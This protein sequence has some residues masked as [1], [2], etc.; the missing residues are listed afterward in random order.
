[1][2]KCTKLGHQSGRLNG[3]SSPSTR[4]VRNAKSFSQI[5]RACL[6]SLNSVLHRGVVGVTYPA[7]LLIAH[8]KATVAFAKM[9]RGSKF[10]TWVTATTVPT[11]LRMVTMLRGICARANFPKVSM[12][13]AIKDMDE[14]LK[15]ERLSF[16]RTARTRQALQPS[17]T[18]KVGLLHRAT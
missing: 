18:G 14:P 5:V 2:H 13:K 6:Q 1:M 10:A 3:H 9:Y 7:P 16:G 12:S 11:L 4:P 15:M 8:G 17:W